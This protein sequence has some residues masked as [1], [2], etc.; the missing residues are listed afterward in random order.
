MDTEHPLTV[1]FYDD[2]GALVLG[3]YEVNYRTGFNDAESYQ[4]TANQ[5]DTSSWDDDGDGLSNIEE[6][7][8]GTNPLLDDSDLPELIFTDTV[9]T[10]FTFFEEAV[11]AAG[12]YEA[13]LLALTLP[14]DIHEEVIADNEPYHF[15]SDT[16]DI[17]ISVDGNGSYSKIHFV[18]PGQDQPSSISSI[19]TRSRQGDTINWSGTQLRYLSSLGYNHW[20]ETVF[21]TSNTTVGRELIQSNSATRTGKEGPIENVDTILEYSYEVVLD[22]DSM[23]SEHTCAVLHGELSHTLETN[24]QTDNPILREATLSRS[25]SDENWAW[26]WNNN[27]DGVANGRGESIELEQRFY[28][29]F[30]IN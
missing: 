28:C 15:Q 29:N 10:G 27:V 5:F 11:N 12:Y 25:S 7:I 19:G 4:I 16:R 2:N 17:D 24:L 13:E 30:P 22:L 20:L 8:A 6:L 3:I 9:G 14:I 21:E 18:N 26:T 1:T 23:D